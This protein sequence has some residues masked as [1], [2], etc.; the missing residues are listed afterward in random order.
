MDYKSL[1]QLRNIY[2]EERNVQS[3][4]SNENNSITY[5]GRYDENS[6]NFTIEDLSG[7][8]VVDGTSFN[9]ILE[10]DGQEYTSSQ[11]KS[12]LE[13]SLSSGNPY[14]QKS[15]VTRIQLSSNELL[16][17]EKFE[18]RE[19]YSE[20][21]ISTNLKTVTDI[22]KHIDWLVSK[23]QTLRNIDEYGSWNLNTT[24]YNVESDTG[25]GLE[26]SDA[27]QSGDNNYVAEDESITIQS[28]NN[29]GI[30]KILTTEITNTT[31]GGSVKTQ[32][33]VPIKFDV[34]NPFTNNILRNGTINFVDYNTIG[35]NIL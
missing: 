29:D 13:N 8:I 20:V 32:I 21:N 23:N 12:F 9:F 35:S 31:E 24:S 11:F 27:V 33:K 22:I 7:V 34:S 25:I 15:N 4:Y 14:I 19:K 6:L 28:I 26:Y 10:I 5:S 30:Q 17:A 3:S 18:V 16:N 1:T 2:P